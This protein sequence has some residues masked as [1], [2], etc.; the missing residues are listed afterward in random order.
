MGKIVSRAFTHPLISLSSALSPSLPPSLPPS[1]P[2][3]MP[4]TT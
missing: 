4:P 3:A 1:A 2:D